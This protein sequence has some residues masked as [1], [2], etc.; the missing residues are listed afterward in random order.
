[1]KKKSHTSDLTAHLKAP[2]QN[3]KKSYPKEVDGKK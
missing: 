2:E 3:G 1:M